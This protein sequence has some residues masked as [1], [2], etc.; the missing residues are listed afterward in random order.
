MKK[1][2]LV[3]LAI[4]GAIALSQPAQAQPV[5]VCAVE[6]ED[7]VAGDNPIICNE[8][9]GGIQAEAVV[10]RIFGLTCIIYQGIGGANPGD[11]D[12]IDFDTGMVDSPQLDFGT[13]RPLQLA[14]GTLGALAPEGRFFYRSQC[15]VNTTGDPY[16]LSH[17]ATP[18]I[19]E[20]DGVSQFTPTA[21]VFTARGLFE[22]SKDLPNVP[23]PYPAV[24][25][26]T[27]WMN[28]PEQAFRADGATG[29]A[30]GPLTGT[31][32]NWVK[33]DQTFPMTEP[34]SQ[35]GYSI[36]GTY[37]ICGDNTATG[38]TVNEDDPL[39]GPAH[40]WGTYVSNIEWKLTNNNL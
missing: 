36:E 25:D 31:E 18:L 3:L 15:F 24:W 38:C 28:S 9:N 22:A 40:P 26:Q 30:D 4:V 12:V 2:L 11:P 17:K 23:V 21:W 27:A 35:T 14:D 19:R 6:I 8:A 32:V 34:A 39:A 7:P 20:E 5:P 1:L 29:I 13:L 10:P 33:T 16:T 37:G